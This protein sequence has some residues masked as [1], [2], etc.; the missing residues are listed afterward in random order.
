M[1][2]TQVVPGT[3]ATEEVE[4]KRRGF[5]LDTFEKFSLTGKVSYTPL[6]KENF[7]Q[8][9]LEQLGGD[10]DK[11][12]GLL[13]SVIRRNTILT[14]RTSLLPPAEKPNWVPSAKIVMTFVNNFRGIPPYS[15]EKDRQKQT[16]MIIANL[17]SQSALME[18]LKTLA[19]AA[20]SAGMEEEEEEE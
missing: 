19:L 15:A 4:I 11:L 8:A 17:K 9:A 18:S 2:T 16:V 6:P 10:Q 13:N 20:A 1:A 12:Y 14:A 3:V 7:L 5:D